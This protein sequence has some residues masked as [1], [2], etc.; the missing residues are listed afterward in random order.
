MRIYGRTLN[1]W[2]ATDEEGRT[3]VS[4]IEVEY[5]DRN[6]DG[7]IIAEGSEDFSPERWKTSVCRKG[8]WSWDGNKLNRG[9]HRW[10]DFHTVVTYRKK[11]GKAV[12]A[13]YKN[14]YN[15]AAVELR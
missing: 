6:Q 4:Q 1:T 15:A 7:Q 12:K 10:F 13:F 11:D 14:L 9:G 3:R 8:V 2:Y 5:T